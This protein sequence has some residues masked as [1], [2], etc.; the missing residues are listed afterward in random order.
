MPNYVF[1]DVGVNNQGKQGR[2]QVCEFY[3]HD[4]RTG[5]NNIYSDEASMIQNISPNTLV[6]S[7]DFANDKDF[8][9]NLRNL[10]MDLN[11]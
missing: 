7:K 10:S 11:I 1:L 8:I 5:S 2:G 4:F 6:I 3:V 9:R